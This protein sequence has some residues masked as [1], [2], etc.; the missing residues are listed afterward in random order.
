MWNL[1]MSVANL[2]LFHSQYMLLFINWGSF[3]EETIKL[4]IPKEVLQDFL[5]LYILLIFFVK[6]KN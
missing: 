2:L 1:E 3:I 5:R 6:Q 4:Y